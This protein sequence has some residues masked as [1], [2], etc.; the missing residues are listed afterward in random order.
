MNHHLY[1]KHVIQCGTKLSSSSYLCITLVNIRCAVLQPV[2][3]PQNI[4]QN[5]K[6]DLL[7][8]DEIGNNESVFLHGIHFNRLLMEF[9]KM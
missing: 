2:S 7:R 6:C 5:S 9:N 8:R 1:D 4:H 3:Q